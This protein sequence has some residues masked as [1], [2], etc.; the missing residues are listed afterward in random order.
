MSVEPLR[1]EEQFKIRKNLMNVCKATNHSEKQLIIGI[2]IYK[3][4]IIIPVFCS[5]FF[6][7]S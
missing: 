1:N 2:K 7:I 6:N 4:K 5:F 3:N